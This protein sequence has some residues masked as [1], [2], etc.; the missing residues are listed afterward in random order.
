MMRKSKLVLKLSG[1]S[2]PISHCRCCQ[3]GRF[4]ADVLFLSFERCAMQGPLIMLKRLDSS[5]LALRQ[6]QL[7]V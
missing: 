5:L 3:K 2:V 4:Q 6:A 7:K 1:A